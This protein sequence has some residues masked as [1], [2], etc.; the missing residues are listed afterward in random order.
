MDVDF[1]N[2]PKHNTSLTYF[3]YFYFPLNV[4]MTLLYKITIHLNNTLQLHVKTR[5]NMRFLLQKKLRMKERHVVQIGNESFD[6]D[7]INN[8]ITKLSQEMSFCV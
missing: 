2:K 1:R 4:T 5:Y 6:L 8:K 7:I 3:I